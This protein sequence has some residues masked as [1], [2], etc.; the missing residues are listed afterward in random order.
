MRVALLALVA[1][2]PRA[3]AGCTVSNTKCYVDSSTRV[4][5]SSNVASNEPITSEYCAQLCANQKMTL[6]G[7]EVATTQQYLRFPTTHP[8]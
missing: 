4:L 1:T 5:G 7:T 2:L 6:S 8:D 3:H